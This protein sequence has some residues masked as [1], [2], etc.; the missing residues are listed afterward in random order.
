MQKNMQ[1]SLSA[2]QQVVSAIV[3][4]GDKYLLIKRMY[5]PSKGMYAF[6]GGR[7]EKGESLQQ[8]VLRE[9]ME[10]TGLTGSNPKLYAEYDLTREGGTLPLSVFKVSVN[11]TSD[12]L[13]QDDAEDLGW[14]EIRETASLEM[15]QSMVDCFAKLT[16]D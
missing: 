2:S 14:Y 16:K 6:P 15:P 10:E 12:A 5:P 11:D 9:L 13:A 8:A 4:N 1:S 7:V 3:Q